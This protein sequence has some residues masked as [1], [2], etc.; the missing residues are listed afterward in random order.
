M[1]LV[2]LTKK[3]IEGLEPK[4]SDK[5]IIRSALMAELD[6]TSLYESHLENLHSVRAMA[7]IRHIMLEEKEHI[8]ELTCLL[9]MID[10]EQSNAI[11]G[12][13]DET[14]IKE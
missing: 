13:S 5:D 8:A 3:R 11:I 1:T 12:I 4:T 2:E 9:N 14:C 6:A 10:D 7:V